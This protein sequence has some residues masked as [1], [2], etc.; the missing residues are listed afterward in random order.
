[1]AVNSCWS[2]G[3]VTYFHSYRQHCTPCN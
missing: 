2:E 3:V 1:M